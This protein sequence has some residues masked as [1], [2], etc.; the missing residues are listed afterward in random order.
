M[1]S[2]GRS[3]S[4]IKSAPQVIS[5]FRGKWDFLSNFHTDAEGFC[6]EKWYQAEKATNE[7]DRQRILNAKTARDAKWLG[8]RIKLREGW[9]E[10][11]IPTM[12]RGIEIKFSSVVMHGL[13]LSTDNAIL[14]EGNWW[15]DVFFG[16][17]LGLG[18]V[19]KCG[20]PHEPFGE[21]HLGK[22]LMERRRLTREIFN[23]QVGSW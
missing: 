19:K 14:I 9:D 23:A 5:S 2:T 15:H 12:A 3:N 7:A 8:A 18:R 10:I 21:N 16:M 20:G 11:R 22:L 1:L 6:L 4:S 17:C 13:L